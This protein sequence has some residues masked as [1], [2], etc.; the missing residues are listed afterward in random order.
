MREQLDLELIILLNHNRNRIEYTVNVNTQFQSGA[1]CNKTIR[2]GI[3][4]SLISHS[5]IH[6]STHP[7]GGDGV[8][9]WLA[10]QLSA[11]VFIFRSE[12]GC[13]W[14]LPQTTWRRPLGLFDVLLFCWRANSDQENGAQFKIY[15]VPIAVHYTPTA[16]YKR[17]VWLPFSFFLFHEENATS[18]PSSSSS[19]EYLKR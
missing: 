18:A 5:F 13:G 14:Q 17:R 8:E 15:S 12:T 11:A 2:D 3:L 19:F 10:F 9:S 7:S 1:E 16:L 4:R 6:S